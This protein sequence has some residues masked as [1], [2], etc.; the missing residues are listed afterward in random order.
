MTAICR[1]RVKSVMFSA[2]TTLRQTRCP[3]R[4]SSAIRAPIHPDHPGQQQVTPRGAL[5]I[6]L[7]VYGAI[8]DTTGAIVH[9]SLQG[10]ELHRAFPTSSTCKEF[11]RTTLHCNPSWNIPNL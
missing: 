1:T 10:L 11:S 8:A 2:P 6:G 3:K 7:E 5:E 4:D 9:C